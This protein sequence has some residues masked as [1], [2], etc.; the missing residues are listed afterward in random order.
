MAARR[1]MI[2]TTI[3]S[4]MSVKAGRARLANGMWVCQ[5]EVG[6]EGP[7]SVSIAERAKGKA[8]ALFGLIH[9]TPL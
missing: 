6:A 9:L 8:G 1:P 4:S 5:H 3:N 2:T 7:E